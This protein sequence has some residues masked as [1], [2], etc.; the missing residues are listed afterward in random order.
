MAKGKIRFTPGSAEIT[1]ETMPVITALA[2][3]LEDC[4]GL[5]ME[6]GGHTDAQG[7]EGGNKA[8]SQARAEAVL[9]ALQGAGWM[10]RE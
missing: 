10:C 6:I 9:L 2:E 7:S 3:V 1:S 8:L 5:K 4:P